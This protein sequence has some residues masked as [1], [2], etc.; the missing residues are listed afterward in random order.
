MVVLCL[1]AILSLCCSLYYVAFPMP[2]SRFKMWYK[3]AHGGAIYFHGE[4][5]VNLRRF[6]YLMS[7]LVKSM[8]YDDVYIS[9]YVNVNAA[10]NCF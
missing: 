3:C 2:M 8:F 5:S 10:S 9:C 1:R 6:L 7:S 4:C